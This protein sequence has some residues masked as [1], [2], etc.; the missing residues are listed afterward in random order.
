MQ[1]QL[2]YPPS[3]AINIRYIHVAC[4]SHRTEKES[5]SSYDAFT[6]DRA[7]ALRLGIDTRLRKLL[8]AR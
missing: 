1:S 5:D 3:P 6:P 2:T 8:H 4:I 7:P